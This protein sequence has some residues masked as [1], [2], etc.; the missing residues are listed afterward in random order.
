MQIVLFY[1]V[2]P[3]KFTA[4]IHWNPKK[5][6]ESK[7][8]KKTNKKNPKKTQTQTQTQRPICRVFIPS[9]P[10]IM[11]VWSFS[12]CRWLIFVTGSVFIWNKQ[13]N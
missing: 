3:M 10:E 6:H 8:K 13:T 12:F 11:V 9:R 1:K 7:R 5:Y 2:P 4:L